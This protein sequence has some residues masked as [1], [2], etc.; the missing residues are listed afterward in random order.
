MLD[1]EFHISSTAKA[2]LVSLVCPTLKEHKSKEDTQRSLNELK[3]LLRTLGLEYC[4]EYI[5]N[6][7]GVDAGT[8]LGKGKLE[9]IAREAKA[10]DTDILVFDV[11]LTASQIRNIKKITGLGVV[12]RVH[13]ILEIFAKHAHT[14]EAKVQIEIAR[15]KYVLPRLSGFWSHLGRQ[16]GGVGVKGGEGEQ[17]IELD[18]RII[19]ERIEFLKKE[20]KTVEKSRNEQRKMRKNKAVTAALVGYTN[21]G[22]S[23]LMNRMCRVDIL[24]EN[25]LFATL[26]S[27]YRMLNPD[28]HP[29]MILI[30]TVGFISNLPNTLIDGFKTTLESA[31][32]AELL[33]IVCDISDPHYEKHLSVTSDVLSELGL[34]DKDKLIVFNKKDLLEDPIKA[35]LIKR[36]YPDSFVVSSFEKDDI[37]SLRKHIIDYFL[38]KQDHYDLFV[39]Y[40]FGH[41]HSIMASKTNII[42]SENHETGIFYRIRVP[43]FIFNTLGIKEYVLA[44]DDPIRKE[45]SL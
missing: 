37:D 3:E 5:Q 15:L 28:T 1:N 45:L 26:D 39:P 31:L 22:K 27:T 25:K 21:A 16:R 18:R 11:E 44:P 12:D 4:G 29:P 24:E 8:I 20:L 38:A 23:S 14:N 33:I 2:S 42:N 10:N 13:I 35:K 34:N 40:E 7:K 41:I 32:E 43:N 17:Q 9:E 30:D 19:R 36:S 6:K